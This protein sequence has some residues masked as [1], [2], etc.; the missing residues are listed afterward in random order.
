MHRLTQILAPAVA[1]ASFAASAHAYDFK[2][3]VKDAADLTIFYG[4]ERTDGGI[5]TS[6]K[7]RSKSA[8]V[9]ISNGTRNVT[10]T[11]D[12]YLR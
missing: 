10:R 11:T 3:V 4:F 1:V 2:I 8:K 9:R 7:V 6:S 5:S 12:I